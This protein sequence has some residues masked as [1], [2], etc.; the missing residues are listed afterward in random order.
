M[1][2]DWCKL[3]P[4]LPL[5]GVDEV[6][7]GC[8]AGPVCAGAVVINQANPW[9]HYT[10]SK[11]L[12]ASRREQYAKQIYQD[13]FVGLGF[14]SVDEIS[15]IN[16]LQASLL[17]MKRAVIDLAE[18]MGISEAHLLIDGNQLI[19]GL[20]SDKR[21]KFRQT[22]LVKGDSRAEPVG[23]ASIFAKVAR[24]RLLVEFASQYPGYGFEDHKGYATAAHR[25]SIARLGPC[26]IHRRTFA[27]VREYWTDPAP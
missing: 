2:F 20:E 9:R 12:S 18:K 21:Y 16:I 5:V 7:R 10:D 22:T 19:P 14:A 6:G 15:Q 4:S 27:G 23:A 26:S 13:H 3:D 17:A 8:L 11:K 1:K 24:D 25:E